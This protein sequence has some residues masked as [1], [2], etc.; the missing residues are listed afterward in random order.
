MNDARIEAHRRIAEAIRPLRWIQTGSERYRE[1][2]VGTAEEMADAVLAL[3][4]DAEITPCRLYRTESW[5]PEGVIEHPRTSATHTRLILRGPVEPA[6]GCI[7][8]QINVSTCLDDPDNP[9]ILRGQT[10]PQCPEHGQRG[11]RAE[12]ITDGTLEP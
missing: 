4:P 2:R 11:A 12:V 6:T 3:F 7:C 10:D 8:P 9:P 1:T 5:E